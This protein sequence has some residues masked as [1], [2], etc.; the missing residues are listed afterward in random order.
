MRASFVLA[1]LSLS[2]IALASSGVGG[3]SAHAQSTTTIDIGDAWFCDSSFQNGVCETTVHAGDAVQW[4]WVGGASHTT[5]NCADDLITCS[6]PREWDSSP[7]ASTGTFSHTFGPEDAGKTFLYR[8][9]IHPGQMRGQITVIAA[10][11]TPTPTPTAQA[12]PEPSPQASPPAGSLTITP[13]LPEPLGESVAPS[14]AGRQPAAVPAG[15]GPPPADGGSAAWPLAIALGLILI[16][17]AL[18]LVL[19]ASRR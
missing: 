7:A 6:G 3:S 16:V 15:G 14:P 18:V 17:P 12:T 5:T 4:Q 1:V 8:C 19:R 2:L 9:Q 11:P 10:E 13:T